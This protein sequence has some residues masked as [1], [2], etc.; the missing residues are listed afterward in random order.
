MQ[1][2]LTCSGISSVSL[3]QFQA[4]LTSGTMQQQKLA[5]HEYSTDHMDAVTTIMAS[6]RSTHRTATQMVMQF[7]RERQFWIK[8]LDRIVAACHNMF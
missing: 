7:E 4:A 8:D 6:L 3:N 5:A 2:S 1:P